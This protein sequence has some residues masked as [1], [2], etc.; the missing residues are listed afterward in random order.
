[1]HPVAVFKQMFFRTTKQTGGKDYLLAGARRPARHLDR[2]FRYQRN[3]RA[4][5]LR[6]VRQFHFTARRNCFLHL[7]FQVILSFCFVLIP[8]GQAARERLQPAI[9]ALQFPFHRPIVEEF[10]VCGSFD[11]VD[12][13]VRHWRHNPSAPFPIESQPVYAGLHPWQKSVGCIRS[14]RV[15]VHIFAIHFHQ[16]NIGIQFPAIPSFFAKEIFASSRHQAWIRLES[17][18]ARQSQKYPG[19]SPT[20]AVPVL[21]DV[22]DVA[23]GFHLFPLQFFLTFPWLVT[24]V[25]DLLRPRID[26]LQLHLRRVPRRNDLRYGF[27]HR[28]SLVYKSF[29]SAG[30][31][32]PEF[33]PILVQIRFRQFV[34]VH[35]LHPKFQL[36]FRRHIVFRRKRWNIVGGHPN[37]TVRGN[38]SRLGAERQTRG[39]LPFDAIAI[40]S[41]GF[42]CEL[43][44]PGE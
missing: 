3:V 12:A 43:G 33:P 8:F 36:V 1:M 25:P 24:Q 10:H 19:D 42:Q 26:L 38:L 39:V 23:R 40:A 20:A 29:H 9:G 35:E 18:G 15:E 30:L 21:P 41:V 32:L 28:L 31:L 2:I 4:D 13:A 34:V 22:F 27:L 16:N 5:P 11:S 44:M 6:L 14:S 7:R 37:D 17:C